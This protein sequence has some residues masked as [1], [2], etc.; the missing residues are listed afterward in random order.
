MHRTLDLSQDQPGRNWMYQIKSTNKSSTVR[1]Y[2]QWACTLLETI[3]I[4]YHVSECW[5]P[6]AKAGWVS[7]T[8]SHWLAPADLALAAKLYIPSTIIKNQMNVVLLL[9]L[10][11]LGSQGENIN[12]L[13]IFL[14]HIWNKKERKILGV[15]NIF[16][17]SRFVFNENFCNFPKVSAFA[18]HGEY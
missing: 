11:R 17:K 8:Y 4:L 1:I 2:V 10:G 16:L 5:N 3:N 18:F 6:A 9:F 15:T 12:L 13:R 7:I 14:V